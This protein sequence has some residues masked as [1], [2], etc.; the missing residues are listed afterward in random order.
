M[1]KKPAFKKD[2][3]FTRDVGTIADVLAA[4]RATWSCPDCC[5]MAVAAL[6]NPAADIR[7]FAYYVR[8]FAGDQSLPEVQESAG[9]ILNAIKHLTEQEIAALFAA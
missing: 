8:W 6:R 2:D 7:L 9:R 1:V 3:T 4:S 5:D